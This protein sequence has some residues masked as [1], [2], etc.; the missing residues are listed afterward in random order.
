MISGAE[1]V[2]KALIKEKVD[3]CF[4]YPGG[5]AIDLFDA[6]Y[7]REEFR[8]IL[9]RHEQG[10]IHA[11]DGYARSTGKVGVCMVTSGPGAT[12]LIT[13]IATAGYDSSP[14]VCITGQVSTQ[15]IGKD[16]FQEV[17]M[18]GISRPIAKY[19]VTV[20]K[21]EELGTIL[22]KAFVIAQS[23]K[24]GVV[25]VDIPKNIQQALGSDIYPET[26]TIR[27][28]QKSQ[29]ISIKNI[30]EAAKILNHAE[31]TVLLIGGGVH[32]GSAHQEVMAFVEKTG[33]PVVSTIMGKGAL[34]SNHPNY[35]GNVGIHGSYAAN[36][37]LMN[38]DVIFA[39]GTRLNDRVTG[40]VATFCPSAKMIHLDIDPA[41]INKN[42]E[43][44]LKLVGDVKEVLPKITAL[45]SRKEQS[46]GC[47][48]LKKRTLFFRFIWKR[49]D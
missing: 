28:G 11:A 7:Q 12:N 19:A 39:V 30:K 33:I 4:A 14:L 35:I 24:P 22:K 16:A 15:L 17:D 47:L 21:R 6:F 23:G 20:T 29:T 32:R 44:H 18:V 36:Q 43:A 1:L 13:G 31:K 37:A 5:Q 38:S 34:S 45:I 25:V 8:V 10:L 40:N 41:V 2:V 48:K 3:V 9:P 49:P 46:E 42:I 26:V 27:G